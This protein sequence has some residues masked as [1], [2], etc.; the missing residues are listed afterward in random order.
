MYTLNMKMQMLLAVV[1]I[2]CAAV[3]SAKAQNYQL[4]WRGT[5]FTTNSNGSVT[6]G[7]FTEQ[8]FVNKIARDNGIDP[9]KLVFVYRPAARDTAVVWASNGAF[10]SD[11]IQMVAGDSTSGYTEIGNPS[12]GIV[13]RQAFLYDEYHSGP[14]GSIV[15][16]EHSQFDSNGNLVND[17]FSGIFQFAYPELGAVY[18]GSFST[19]NRIGP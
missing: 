1:L 10:V 13:V 8:S 5:Y 4:F 18:Y 2:G 12:F 3:P 17:H 11:V 16:G 19:G 15:G 6:V 7:S 9:S 14:I